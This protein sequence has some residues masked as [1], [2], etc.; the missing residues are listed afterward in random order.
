MRHP[1]GRPTDYDPKYCDELVKF[2]D[3]EPHFETPCITTYKDGSTRE[4]IKLIPSDLPLLSSFATKIGV[5]R[6]T[7][8]RWGKKHKEFGN[9]LKTA[10]EC[11]RR[12][13][14]TNGLQGLYSTSFAI[15]TAKNVIRWR[16][17]IE[18]DVTSKGQRL[19]GLVVIKDGDSSK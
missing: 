8:F 6:S 3:I 4:E 9:A 17:K 7:L 11:Q 18:T 13:L 2:F 16:D 14:I 12:I 15:F 1:G 10:K 5:H 19:E